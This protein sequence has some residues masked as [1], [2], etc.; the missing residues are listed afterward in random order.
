[1]SIPKYSFVR[2]SFLKFELKYL[3]CINIASYNI[4]LIKLSI[5]RSKK[6]NSSFIDVPLQG[7]IVIPTCHSTNGAS[8]EIVS[9]EPLLDNH[10]VKS[11]LRK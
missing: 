4:V 7:T 10:L 3:S 8:H 6:K 2:K 9:T 11:K 5:A 1:M